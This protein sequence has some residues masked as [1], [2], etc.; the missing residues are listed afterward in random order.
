M[1][2]DDNTSPPVAYGRPQVAAAVGRPMGADGAVEMTTTG[3]A[4]VT[5]AVMRRNDGVDALGFVLLERQSPTDARRLAG[6]YVSCSWLCL[7]WPLLSCRKF[8]APDEDTLR[9]DCC[10]G[11]CGGEEA[12]VYKRDMDEDGYPGPPNA[13]SSVTV[14]AAPS[15]FDLVHAMASAP[16]PP[17]TLA[18][19]ASS[20]AS[21]LVLCVMESGGRAAGGAEP[22]ARAR[23]GIC[24]PRRE[25]TADS[26][27]R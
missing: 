12:P 15:T 21:A 26:R 10:G 9:A 11:G 23:L 25:E 4:H 14:G 2:V 13:F 7:P 3:V 24:P 17:T 20:S 22:E 5:P 27:V 16:A 18:T 1:R 6:F 19:S 8:S